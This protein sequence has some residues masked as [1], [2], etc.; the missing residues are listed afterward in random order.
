MQPRTIQ[1]K[2]CPRCEGALVEYSDQYGPYRECLQCGYMRD[3]QQ[4]P[5]PLGNVGSAK[6]SAETAA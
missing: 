6:E 2:A 1:L 3:L 4:E 5:Y